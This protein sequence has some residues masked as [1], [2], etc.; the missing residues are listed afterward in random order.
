MVT[1]AEGVTKAE[2][3]K[4]MDEAGCTRLALIAIL[5]RYKMVSRL[6]TMLPLTFQGVYSDK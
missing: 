6:N 3:D 2:E 1:E 4:S 5:S